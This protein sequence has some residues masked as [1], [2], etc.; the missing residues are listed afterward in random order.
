MKP[1]LLDTDTLS[2]VIKGR[3]AELQEKALQYL[4]EHGYF[5]FFHHHTL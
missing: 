2:E 3:D 1:A 5:T 4:T